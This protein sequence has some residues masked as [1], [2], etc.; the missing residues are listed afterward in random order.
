[1][2]RKLLIAAGCGVLVLLLFQAVPYG[3][4]HANPRGTLEARLPGGPGRQAFDDACADCHSNHTNWRWYASV[5]PAS[6]LVQ[7]DVEDARAV[8]NVSEW[9]RPQ[10]G[11]GDVLE[12]TTSGSMPPIQY[13]VAH[14]SSRLSSA[15]KQRLAAWFTRLYATD[16][17][18]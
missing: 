13:E 5:A 11:L 2:A 18:P 8:F 16:P 6:W 17:P 12:Q 1:M 7:H 4:T 15:D 14:P 10:P 9:D 3:R